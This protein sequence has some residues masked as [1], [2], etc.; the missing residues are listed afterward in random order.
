MEYHFY[1]LN[2]D[3]P[4]SSH[5]GTTQWEDSVMGQLASKTNEQIY[6]RELSYQNKNS[7]LAW[8]I[9]D[10]H[11]STEDSLMTYFRAYSLDGTFLP[12]AV[13][14]VNYGTVP[15]RIKGGFKY[16][17]EFGNEY[18]IPVQNNFTTPNTGGYTVSVLDLD[19]PSEGL[20]F[21]MYKQGAQHQC[22]VISFRL[23]K[24]GENYP[25]DF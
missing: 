1:G 10:A 17:P 16:P 9:A 23:F 21:G 7:I 12:Q 3:T 20:S 5:D 19:Y 4:L 18:Y 14:G 6:L 13:F 15:S 22:L 2:I 25:N 8:R 24:I 11:F